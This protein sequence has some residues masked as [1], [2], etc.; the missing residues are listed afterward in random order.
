MSIYGMRESPALWSGFRDQE[1]RG[2]TWECE[3]DG[4]IKRLKLQQLVSDDQVWKVVEEENLHEALGYIM[5]YIDDL[6]ITGPSEYPPLILR[7][8]V[9]AMGSG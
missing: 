5:V 9:G 2:A 3:V 1:L 7:M 8:G 4:I 6:L